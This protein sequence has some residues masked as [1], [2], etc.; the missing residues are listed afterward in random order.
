MSFDF[1]PSLP[2]PPPSQ[3]SPR[4]LPGITV[5]STNALRVALKENNDRFHIFFND[6]RFHKYVAAICLELRFLVA[7]ARMLTMENTATPHIM[8]SRSGHLVPVAL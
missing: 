7:V 3:Q 6:K 5:Q 2:Q 4:T 8:S 1:P